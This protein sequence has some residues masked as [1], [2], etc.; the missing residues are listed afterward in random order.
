MLLETCFSLLKEA[1]E[2]LE[3]DTTWRRGSQYARC[4]DCEYPSKCSRKIGCLVVKDDYYRPHK[5]LEEKITTLLKM[6]TL[7]E[8][9]KNERTD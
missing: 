1:L 2:A 8:Q 6:S 3:K 4:P 9:K 7:D 5:K